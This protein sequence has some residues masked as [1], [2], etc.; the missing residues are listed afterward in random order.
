MRRLFPIILLCISLTSNAQT[1]SFSFNCTKDTL[2][3]CTIPC[4]T[5]K[6]K[7]PHLHGL[8]NTYDVNPISGVPGGCYTPYVPPETPGVVTPFVQDDFY[9]G[10][11]PI[12]F[13]FPFYGTMYNSLVAS[14]NGYVSFDISLAGLPCHWTLA[15]GNVPNASYDRALIMGPYHDID[16][17]V[18][19]PYS[20]NMVIGYSTIG[21]AP[22]RKWIFS[23][24]KVPL[25]STV[26]ATC[27]QLIENTHQIVLYES[28]GIIE[29]FVKDKQICTSWNGGKAMIG[30]QDF[31][32]T[33][34]MVAP[35]RGATSP[36]WG[37]IGMN[38]SWRFVPSAGSS[39]FKR[40]ELLDMSG[41]IISTGTT[42]SLGNSVLEA[43]FPNICPVA[44]PATYVVRSVYQKI[45]D[46][47]VEIFGTD[48]VTVTRDASLPMT[49]TK[50]E[51]LCF[52]GTGTI[53][54][55]DPL[56]PVY[57]YSINGTTWQTSPLFTVPAG[58]YNV[59]TRITGTFC[60]GISNIVVNEPSLLKVDG[61]T[62]PPAS[63][64]NNDGSITI[65][66]SGGSPFYQYSID[67]GVTYQTNNSF[68]GLSVGTY[69][70][71]K[72]KDA[73]GCIA[74]SS[75]T[76]NLNDQ[77][78]L[79]LGNDTTIC[80]GSNV[81]L[82]PQT[83]LQ[84]D[85]FKWTPS[86]A[87][88]FD[89]IKNPV[90][91]PSDTIHY[92]L[93]AKWGLCKR[94]DDIWVKIL[95]KPIVSAGKDTTICN[96]TT[97]FLS[98][99]ATNLSGGVNYA[100]TPA[101]KVT[102][103][104]LPTAIAQPDSTQLY[105][106][107]V[108]D[109]YGC[110]F[111]VSDDI[112]VTMR[113]PVPAFAGN[114]TNAV[115]GIPHQLYG[116]GGKNYYWTPTTPLNNPFAK[117]PLATLSADTRFTLLVTDDIGCSNTDDVFIK[118]YKGP[119]YYLP[120]A[121]TP[122]GDGLNDIFKPVPVGISLTQYFSIYNRNGELVF[123]TNQWLKGWDGTIKGKKASAGAYIWMIKGI[124]RDGK[125]VEMKGTVLLMH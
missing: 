107:T 24:Y 79:N 73:N 14:T 45:D 118:V 31:S 98:G 69:N 36:P 68:S 108:T 44:S 22:Y 72:V 33:Q 37:S 35:G 38:E 112:L 5:L 67:N 84:T 90:A 10:V 66:A 55:T 52:G 16:P 60:S 104:N 64:S 28:T 46:P 21:T 77:M 54:V 29:V 125:I 80:V 51:P 4:I 99:I 100:W 13:N 58:T 122:N 32:R 6:A 41:N 23:F 27:G 75:A 71:I 95:H 7:I 42:S 114:D 91:S 86:T 123:Q 97:A 101:A 8:G 30:I 89:N 105:T 53:T 106:L 43:S 50:T 111:S 25:Y 3:S 82:Q 110:N 116:S 61:I 62:S 93:T 40:V 83:N 81:T 120:N 103:A 119:T 113:P 115:Y 88:N 124:D 87:L 117:N 109:N 63:C 47:A 18:A 85:T 9:S 70:N 20:P 102:P 92:F 57:E 56:G 12:G 49:V 74:A 121:F 1:G 76:I 96:K 19:V 78:F 34:G 94:S 39:L 65:A 26:T 2:I 48:T 15:P 59:R 11:I 17:E